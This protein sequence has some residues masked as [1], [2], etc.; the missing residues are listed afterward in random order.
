[1]IDSNWYGMRVS[2][3]D[4]RKKLIRKQTFLGSL[5]GIGIC[6][7]FF[8]LCLYS[9]LNM[10]NSLTKL[11]IEVPKLASELR[12]MQEE[13]VR[14]KYA[15]VEFENPQQLLQLA[16]ST[17]FSH[18]KFPLVKEVVVLPADP[19]TRSPEQKQETFSIHPHIAIASCQP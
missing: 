12:Q 2:L 17:F 9:Y 1:M 14:L 15:V 10:Q 16:N 6:L 8:A 7:S 11:R 4:R 13:N 19:I 18:L 3:E 5:I